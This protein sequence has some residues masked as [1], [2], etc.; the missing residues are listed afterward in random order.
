VKNSD[1]N[2]NN[3][4]DEKFQILKFSTNDVIEFG[5]LKHIRKTNVNINNI[6]VPNKNIF[7]IQSQVRT[8]EKKNICTIIGFQPDFAF[9][10]FLNIE[11]CVKMNQRIVAYQNNI[12]I[13]IFDIEPK[14]I[15]KY[16]QQPLTKISNH[17]VNIDVSKSIFF[18]SYNIY[19]SIIIVLFFKA[20]QC[21]YVFKTFKTKYLNTSTDSEPYFF[22][23]QF[24][25]SSNK[26]KSPHLIYNKI[27]PVDNKTIFLPNHLTSTNVSNEFITYKCIPARNK[28][29]DKSLEIKNWFIVACYPNMICKYKFERDIKEHQKDYSLEFLFANENIFKLNFLDHVDID[30]FIMFNY[31][32]YNTVQFYHSL[33]K[34]EKISTNSLVKI[35]HT[36]EVN[37]EFKNEISFDAFHQFIPSEDL[38]NPKVKIF[39]QLVD[40]KKE[41][42]NIINI[43][44][45]AYFHLKNKSSLSIGHVVVQIDN[46]EI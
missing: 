40:S 34:K 15:V 12:L 45:Y 36:L 22:Q 23:L 39:K 28:Q 9:L 19:Y 27:T 42:G 1:N 7:S 41:H 24:N 46:F 14:F 21:S 11:S 4:N 31:K 43:G 6:L 3:F 38:E 44:V 25:G 29:N 10:N 16:N 20:A 13:T 33:S 5:Y 26:L 32:E 37:N 18:F 2:Y 35:D 30:I 17:A 8:L